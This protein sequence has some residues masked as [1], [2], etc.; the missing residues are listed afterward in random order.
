[1]LKKN[2]IKSR[3]VAKI[4]FEIPKDEMPEGLEINSIHLVGDFNIWDY[5][6]I[7]MKRVKGG[8]YRVVIELEPGCEYQFRYLV[9]GEHWCNDWHADAYRPTGFDQDNCVVVT[10]ASADG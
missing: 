3:K 6:S 1:M 4:T 9:N 8:A 5:E 2:Y 7:P 10:P